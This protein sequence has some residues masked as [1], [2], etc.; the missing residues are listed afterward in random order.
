MKRLFCSLSLVFLVLISCAPSATAGT[1]PPTQTL[2]IPP[3]STSRPP[4]PSPTPIP[5]I[6]GLPENI[7]PDGLGV[8]IHYEFFPDTYMPLPEY[9][10][11]KEANLGFVRDDMWPGGACAAPPWCFEYF[12]RLVENMSKIGIRVIFNLQDYENAQIGTEEGR[13]KFAE[14]AGDAAG[15]LKGKGVIWEIWNEPNLDVYWKPYSKPPDYDLLVRETAPAIRAAD[16]QAVVIG[17][18]ISTLSTVFGDNSWKFL[19][20]L[21]TAGTFEYFDAVDVHLYNGGSPESQIEN[22]RKL[23]RLVDFYSPD[24]RI[25]ITSSEWGYATGIEYYRHI[26]SV[27]EQTKYVPRSFLVK[28]AHEIQLSI[29]YDWKNDDWDPY[30]ENSFG[31]ITGSGE[32]KPAYLALQTLTTTLDGYQYVRRIAAGTSHDYLLLFRKDDSAVL[33]AW[34]ITEAH[35]LA[36]A[37]VNENLESIS[38]LGEKQTLSVDDGNL[39]LQLSDSPQ[40]IISNHGTYGDESIF[41]KPNHAFFQ[42]DETG[43]GVVS[44]TLENPE[45]QPQTFLIQAKLNDHI[46]GEQEVTVGSKE[47][48]IVD[49]PVQMKPSSGTLDYLTTISVSINNGVQSAWV[50][51]QLPAEQP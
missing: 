44:I 47:T 14:F 13:K 23:R 2:T 4:S 30:G 43:G 21:G 28:T 42:V 38:M 48:K 8:A 12:D 39:N 19:Q 40:Y 37:N 17:P 41:W 3:T 10:L 22:L 46:I 45:N 25:P 24:R 51:L 15:H 9:V 11:L 16:P 27:E 20:S 32:L 6:G 31:V 34:T 26:T 36:F 49:L 35:P 5:P 18:S 33:A 50:W 29:W 1:S 7:L